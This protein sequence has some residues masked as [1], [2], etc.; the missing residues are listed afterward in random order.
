VT[1]G[2]GV[3]SRPLATRSESRSLRALARTWARAVAG[4]S[5]VPMPIRDMEALLH[6]LVQR[7]DAAIVSEPFSPEAGREVGVTLVD[8]HFTNAVS[9]SRTVAV[10]Q[11]GPPLEGGDCAELASRW[12]VLVGAVAEGYASALQ[13]RALREQEEIINAAQMARAQAEQ[14]LHVSE[15]RFQAVFDGARIG[16]GIGDVHGRILE[17]NPELEKMLGYSADEFRR[18]R[19][20]DFVHAT[21][22][23]SVWRLYEELVRGERDHFRVEKAYTHAGGEPVWTQLT[24][25]SLRDADGCPTYQLAL[26]HDVTELRKLQ[27]QL[28]HEAHHDDLTQL[29]NRKT[30]L[31]ELDDAFA[32]A[33]PETRIGLCFID[34]DGFKGVNDTLGHEVGDRLLVALARRI[35]DVVTASGHLVARLG[36]DEFVVLVR[37]STGRDQVVELA[38][39]L[40]AELER[41]AQVNGR[42]IRVTASI[43]IVER[44]V[45]G[46]DPAELLR[47][48]DITLY[49][50]KDEGKSRWAI[51]EPQRGALDINRYTLTSALPAALEQQQFIV[52]YQPLVRI[53]DG[54]LRG[55][56]ALVRWQH[57]TLGRISPDEF[58]GL[59]EE[60]GLIV[61]L[62]R[63]VLQTACQQAREWFGTG[64][65]A[66]FISVNLA[67]QQLC[68]PGLMQ[69]VSA[70]LAGSGLNPRQLQLEITESAVVGTDHIT[71]ATLRSLSDLGLRIAIDDFGTGYSNLAYLRHLPVTDLKLAASFIHGLRSAEAVDPVDQQIVASLVAL[72]H[73]LD[74]NVTAEGVETETQV[75]LLRT[76]GC[77]TGQGQW[78]GAAAS[79]EDLDRL[80]KTT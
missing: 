29:P 25:S 30:F 24:V 35:E 72:A 33:G 48:A 45:V 23:D 27:D 73:L 44:P 22:D 47:A 19:V 21:D 5:Y 16:I 78:F 54:M 17:A 37:G 6:G 55:V 40:L 66:P 58:V 51:Y 4:S 49:W 75:D 59:A 32:G 3:S 31:E 68:A 38:E 46:I 20:Q 69:D 1:A 63:W 60:S 80:L 13:E 12:R 18:L 70:A 77:D 7:L 2:P 65:H 42:H 74:L 26:V 71:S 56:E 34:L 39:R 14:A 79:A 9:L 57:P 61:P 15:N 36:G 11:Q 76:I 41:P 52:H 8:A 50:A 53:S 43:G 62:G 28:M 67:A 10:L 64:P